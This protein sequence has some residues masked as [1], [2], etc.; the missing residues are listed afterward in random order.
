MLVAG[1]EVA[2]ATWR[3]GTVAAEL[4]RESESLHALL[5]Q[6]ADQNAAHLTSLSAL[7]QAGDAADRALLLEL[8]RSIMRFYPSVMAVDLVALDAMEPGMGT[9]RDSPFA[10]RIEREVRDAARRSVGE[11]VLLPSPACGACYLLVK[12]S[13]NSDRV[14]HGLALEV[15]VRALSSDRSSYWDRPN[16]ALSI[17]LPD[18]TS[19]VEGLVGT[20]APNEPDVSSLPAGQGDELVVSATLGSDTQPLLVTTHYR[21]RRDDLLPWRWAIGGPFALAVLLVLGAL[22]AHLIARVRRAEIDAR[23]GAFEARLS[24]ASR[25][26]SLGEMASGMAHELNQPLTAILAQSQAGLRLLRRPDTDAARVGEVLEA[27]VAQ[28]RRASTILSRLREWSSRARRPATEVSVNECMR[29]VF[30]LVAPE[31]KRLRVDLVLRTDPSDPVI[32]AD[33][34]EMEQVIFNLVRNSLDSLQRHPGTSA[35][36]R[37]NPGGLDSVAGHAERAGAIRISS[38]RS[39][40]RVTVEV[41]D[42]GAGVSAAMRDRLFEPFATDKADGMGL[43]LAL[44]ARIVERSNGSLSL[45]G[46]AGTGTRATMSLPCADVNAAER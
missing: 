23:L 37:T 39:G 5:A 31:A 2:L 36:P 40:G 17:A 32:A 46:D 9:R 38:A 30:A 27:N 10:A 18:G 42:D 34:V 15:D 26:N 43:G 12:R 4:V 19:L 25:V 3:R 20:P 16:T 13:P 6:R 33:A 1:Y 45:V 24:H 28:A 41:H 8:S 11:L 35:V 21:L 44:C 29:N 22:L 7:A 14:R